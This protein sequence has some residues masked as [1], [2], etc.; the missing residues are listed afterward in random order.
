VP[1]HVTSAVDGDELELVEGHRVAGLVQRVLRVGL[2][3]PL[4]PVS[5]NGRCVV[6]VHRT[7]TVGTPCNSALTSRWLQ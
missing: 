6:S 3:Q 5:V 4:V 7:V 1:Y 2:G